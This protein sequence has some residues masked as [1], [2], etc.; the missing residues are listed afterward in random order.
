MAIIR[1]Q[2]SDGGGRSLGTGF[3]IHK[4]SGTGD[5]TVTYDTPFKNSPVVVATALHTDNGGDR[6]ATLYSTSKTAFSITTWKASKGEKRDTAF[7]FYSSD[8]YNS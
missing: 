5:Y 4:N 1:G 3:T 6:E 7:T 2:V 8:D